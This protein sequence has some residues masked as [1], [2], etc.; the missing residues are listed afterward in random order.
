MVHSLSVKVLLGVV[1][2][3]SYRKVEIIGVLFGAF[4]LLFLYTMFATK[5]DAGELWDGLWT[6]KFNDSEWVALFATGE[7]LLD[8]PFLVPVG[9]MKSMGAVIDLA[10]NAITWK[11]HGGT[12]KIEAGR[13]DAGAGHAGAGAGVGGAAL[14]S[15][16]KHH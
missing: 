16:I 1:L 10:N 3:G 9:L 4:E 15:A 12:A 2:S 14:L 8:T 6:F 11:A 13:Q 7:P 5:P